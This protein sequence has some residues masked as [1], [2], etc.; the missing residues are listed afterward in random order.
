MCGWLG[1]VSEWGWWPVF[2]EN[3]IHHLT[4]PCTGRSWK[5]GFYWVTLSVPSW[6]WRQA[7]VNWIL[8]SWELFGKET[9]GRPSCSLFSQTP[10]NTPFV[11]VRPCAPS[12]TV[13]LSAHFLSPCNCYSNPWLPFSYTSVRSRQKHWAY[14][15]YH[16]HKSW[17]YGFYE[18]LWRGWNLACSCLHGQ[19]HYCSLLK[20]PTATAPHNPDPDRRT[21]STFHKKVGF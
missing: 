21:H 12:S 15:N 2:C 10:P 17:F 19:S 5:S 8:G 11:R 6:T 16:R 7:L 9:L 20:H 18:L 1:T 13:L 14:T 4:S 3:I